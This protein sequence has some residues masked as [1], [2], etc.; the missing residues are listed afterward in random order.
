MLRYKNVIR[1]K[2][3]LINKIIFG[4]IILQNF[5]TQQCFYNIYKVNKL[6][7]FINIFEIF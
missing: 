2:T 5:Q 1:E 7:N 4:C 6:N 3:G